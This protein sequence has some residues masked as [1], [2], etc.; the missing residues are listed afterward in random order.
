MP[1]VSLLALILSLAR[2]GA[3]GEAWRLFREAGL[4]GER[5]NPAV[6]ALHGRLLADEARVAAGAARADLLRQAAEAWSAAGVLSGA[7]EHLIEAASLWR[8]AGD[9]QAA[10]P[11]AGAA[12][13]RLDRELD[14]DEAAYGLYAARAE[15]LLLLGRQGRA[16]ADLDQAIRIA[17]LAWDDH[18]ATLRRLAPLSEAAGLDAGWLE[19]LRPPR[20]LHFAGHMSLTAGVADLRRRVREVLDTE[21]PGIAYGDL[22]A[23]PNAIVAEE[24][25]AH[26]V[27]VNIVL[28]SPADVFR[29]AVMERRGGEWAARYDSVLAAAA[30]VRSVGE[31]TRSPD[32][33]SAQLVAEVAMG[34]AAMRARA[35]ETEAIQLVVLDVDERGGGEPGGSGRIRAL[36][37]AS[38][39]RQT[40]ILAPRESRAL[41][42]APAPPPS[43]RLIALLAVAV[44]DH[45]L[46]AL[47]ET[48]RPAPQPLAAPDGR[49]GAF[50]LAYA[51]PAAAAAAAHAVR[52][53]LGASV[54]IAGH[55]GVMS[56]TAFPGAMATALAGQ[57]AAVPIAMLA[58]TPPGACLFSGALAAAVC[59]GD[60]DA[61][62]QPFG[63]FFA[64]AP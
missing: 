39:R 60:A 14:Q 33:L 27:Q 53:G 37:A 40:V 18:A 42:P 9:A 54:R 51:T 8:L 63:D 30:S 41:P 44:A 43:D 45:D 1:S 59:A 12:L 48:L 5:G 21:A 31:G 62:M 24:L 55:Y 29:A 16:R 34:E 64:V 28:P 58:S 26:G 25:Q 23:G 20:C 10:A 22:V 38:G 15:A 2:A 7:S 36:W 17:P 49:S 57:A 50:L 6:L 32:Q 3:T 61:R 11:L 19:V 13:D 52:A 46:A 56:I 47:T 35:L 4:E